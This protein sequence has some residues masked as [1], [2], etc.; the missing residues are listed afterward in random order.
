MESLGTLAGG[1]AHGFNNLLAVI[2]GYSTLL[3]GWPP[4]PPKDVARE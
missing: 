4:Q 2:S 3:M 1:I